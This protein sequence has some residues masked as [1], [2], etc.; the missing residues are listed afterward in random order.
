MSFRLKT[1]TFRRVQQLRSQGFFP[2]KPSVHT[3][4]FSLKTLL[5]VNQN[6]YVYI[7]YQC[8]R[9]RTVE[10]TMTKNIASVCS[11]CIVFYLLLSLSNVLVR[12][13]NGSVYANR[14]MRFR[15]Q[16]KRILLKTHQCGQDLNQGIK[17][18]EP[19]FLE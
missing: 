19:Y 16:R 3:N 7:S 14:S 1:N 6:E 8:Q 15:C 18:N 17:S 13:Q 5:K 4:T 11:M 10:K 9:S 2:F 12:I